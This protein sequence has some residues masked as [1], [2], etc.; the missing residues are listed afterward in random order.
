MTIQEFINAFP[1][2]ND[3]FYDKAPDELLKH[4]TKI[5]ISEKLQDYYKVLHELIQK[6]YQ[7]EDWLIREGIYQQILDYISNSLVNKLCPKE[8]TSEDKE[9]YKKCV[10]LSWININHLVKS[11][12]MGT[13]EISNFSK[14]VERILLLNNPVQQVKKINQIEEDF[15]ERLEDIDNIIP[16][17]IY[18]I[19]QNKFKKY[20]STIHF[21]NLF[22]ESSKG[23]SMFTFGAELIRNLSEKNL[24]NVTKEEFEINCKR[25]I[26][27]N[28]MN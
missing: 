5:Q 4:E 19:I 9:F 23:L 20:V 1:N 14:K 22:T 3:Y 21:C 6:Y 17:L 10:S 25:A 11:S 2:L 15:R 16:Y 26:K 24:L 7:K 8:P 18:I 13:E 27:T 12:L 28:E